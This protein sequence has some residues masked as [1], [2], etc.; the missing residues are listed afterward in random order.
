MSE[1]N[2]PTFEQL[3]DKAISDLILINQALK[4]TRETLEDIKNGLV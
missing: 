3:I 2:Q 1:N 4:E